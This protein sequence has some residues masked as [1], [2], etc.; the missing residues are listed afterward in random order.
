MEEPL[1]YKLPDPRKSGK[2]SVEEALQKRRSHRNYTGSPLSPEELS[3][4]LWSAYGIT[5]TD[6]SRPEFRGGFRTAPSAGATYPLEVYAIIGKVKGVEPGVYRYHSAKNQIVREIAEDLRE[7]LAAAALNQEMIADAPA[8]LFFSAIY[9]RT[10]QRYGERGKLRYVPMDLGHAGQN[11]YLQAEALGLG[12][13]AIG[14]F[15]DDKV[16]AVLQLPAEEEPLYIMPIGKYY[17]D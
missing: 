13:C 6:T 4:V 10:T 5:Y 11:V 8:S 1:A 16:R 2:I 15:N 9:T 17:R 3:Q 14:A 7:E 12:T